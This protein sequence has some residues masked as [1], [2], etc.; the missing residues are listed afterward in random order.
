MDVSEIL[1]SGEEYFNR[2]AE[3]QKNEYDALI[4]SL[5]FNTGDVQHCD[6]LFAVATPSGLNTDK[7]KADPQHKQAAKAIY[8][9]SVSELE[10]IALVYI[11]LE[12]QENEANGTE[13][14]IYE[15]E[16]TDE[17]F[18]ELLDD[19]VSWSDK[20]F[21]K[22]ECPEKNC[23]IHIEERH[24]PEWDTAKE[25]CDTSVNAYY[26]WRDDIQPLIEKNAH[27]PS[28]TSQRQDWD[29][30]IQWRID[31]WNLVYSSLVGNA[32]TSNYGYDCLGELDRISDYYITNLNKTPETIVEQ[33]TTCDREHDYHS[34]HL[35]VK[36]ADQVMN[37]WNFNDTERQW[38]ELTFNGLQ[39]VSETETDE[40]EETS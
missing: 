10:A 27:I 21:E 28:S 5:Y 12:K 35:N 18:D 13:Y 20:V 36:T 24:N 4:D 29:N 38:Y 37:T 7:V 11:Y 23:T 3:K 2:A 30:N 6:L 1:E 19:M 25:N 14:D 40:T 22:Q 33:T 8:D 9:R 26:E 39:L 34:I 16:F 31:N 32:Y 17:I 15:V